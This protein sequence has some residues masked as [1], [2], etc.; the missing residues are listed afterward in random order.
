MTMENVTKRREKRKSWN[1]WRKT[2]W[3]T[4]RAEIE[5]SLNQTSPFLCDLFVYVNG[6][7]E[8]E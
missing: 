5:K 2:N 8:L 4:E 1:T 6:G 7:I 3:E